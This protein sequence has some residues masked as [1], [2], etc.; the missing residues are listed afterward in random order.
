MNDSFFQ[1]GGWIRQA[2]SG[3][4]VDPSLEGFGE[5]I[6]FSTIRKMPA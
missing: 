4:P 3:P 5:N 1:H 6:L 2:F